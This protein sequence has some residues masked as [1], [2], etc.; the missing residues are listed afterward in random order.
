MKA[1]AAQNY[2]IK[3]YTFIL[4]ISVVIPKVPP[5][6]ER[7]TFPT[8]LNIGVVIRLPLASET[9]ICQKDVYSFR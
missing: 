8:L 5:P 2:Y 9:H 6:E 3:L 4:N 1:L 7:F